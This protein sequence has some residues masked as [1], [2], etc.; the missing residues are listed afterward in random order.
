M[1]SIFPNGNMFAWLATAQNLSKLLQLPDFPFA[2][3]VED[4]LRID[5]EG[6]ECCLI[7]GDNL[8]ALCQLTRDYS[9]AVNFCYIDPPYNTGARFVYDDRRYSPSLGTWG[10]HAAWMSFMLPRL[11]MMHGLL[12]DAGVVAISIDDYEYSHLK[13]L[14]DHVFGPDNHLGTLVVN[15]SKNGR[16]SKAHIAVC[17]EYVLVYGKTE[18][19]T[20]HGLP[21]LDFASYTKRDEHGLY[22]TDG[23]FRKK[24]EAS[25]R[26]D[27]P[28]MFYPLYYDTHGNVLTE[29]ISGNLKEVLP[30]DSKGIERRW[31]WGLEKTRAEA[32]KLYASPK[33]V[34]YVKNY[35]TD[36][37]RVKIRSIWDS[38]RYLTERA[39]KEISAIYGEKVFETPKP[40]GLIE[41][42]IK[43]C[44]RKD[45]LILD[46]FCGTATTAHAASNVNREDGGARK[47]LLVEQRARI[48]DTHPAASK[49]FRYIA[50]IAEYRLA[51]LAERDT[52]YSYRKF[53]LSAP[54]E[55]PC[56][57]KT[58]ST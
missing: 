3:A 58:T 30:I 56:A 28:N 34:V 37:K 17:H 43:C 1:S 8:A 55:E 20:I 21:E 51:Y 41:D 53:E 27:R 11:V 6:V 26:E 33:G 24:G 22:K 18:R 48:D 9:G 25:R 31:L 12:E 42:L 14:L 10:K 7:E 4:S 2:I 15:R 13:I 36:K 45:G 5:L 39:T 47:V 44:A 19:S 46:F 29:N 52:S 16:G 35:L 23:L 32:W 54:K 38:S 50:D 57:A 40:L 49:G